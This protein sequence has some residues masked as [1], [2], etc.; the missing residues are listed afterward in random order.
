MADIQEKEKERTQVDISRDAKPGTPASRDA[1]AARLARRPV[2][3][4]Q[5]EETP[6]ERPHAVQSPVSSSPVPHIS[7]TAAP[8]PP[9]GPLAVTL[10]S[11]ADP[12][13]TIQVLPID[14]NDHIASG[15]WTLTVAG[16]VPLALNT[17][18]PND[19]RD[20]R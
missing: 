10:Y 2:V 15:E 19:Q 18:D 17:P 3:S 7:T 5:L 8:R 13:T 9:E 12:N 6:P 20:F 11:V 1:V 16:D 4:A 14:A